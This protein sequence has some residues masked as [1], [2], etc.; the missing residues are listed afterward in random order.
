VHVKNDGTGVVTVQGD[1]G[2]DTI[3]TAAT[4]VTLMPGESRTFYMN[5]DTS[6]RTESRVAAGPTWTKYTVGHAALQAAATSN[7]ITLFTLPAAGI[8][9]E[10]KVKHSTAFSG[11]AIASYTVKV[12]ITGTLGKYLA[13]FDEIEAVSTG[14]N[15]DQSTAGSVD[16]WVLTSA[17]G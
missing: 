6:W 17:A 14:A 15:L 1:S 11:G 2:T 4:S 9:H 3:D 7:N 10:V 12:G 16:I 5:A 13:A 8:I